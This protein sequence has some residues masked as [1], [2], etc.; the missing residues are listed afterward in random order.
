MLQLYGKRLSLIA[1]KLLDW[2]ED[3]VTNIK[4]L[5]NIPVNKSTGTEE[6]QYSAINELKKVEYCYHSLYPH[7]KDIGLVIKDYSKNIVKGLKYSDASVKAYSLIRLLAGT[8]LAQE[9]KEKISEILKGVYESKL[10]LFKPIECL[11]TLTIEGTTREVQEQL[12][13]KESQRGSKA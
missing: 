13:N 6:E 2:S 1:G 11:E 9:V 10:E 5:K 7:Y 12:D 4:L 8:I 3:K